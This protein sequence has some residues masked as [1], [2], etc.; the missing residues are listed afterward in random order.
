M[1]RITAVLFTTVGLL[2]ASAALAADQ[3]VPAKAPSAMTPTEIKTHNEGLTPTDPAYIKCRKTLEIGSL[4]KK[5]V[6][7]NAQRSS[8]SKLTRGRPRSSR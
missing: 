5:A 3:P 1:T 6:C 8:C 2:S 4:V 7:A